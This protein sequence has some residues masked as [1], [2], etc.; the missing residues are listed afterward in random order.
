M[1]PSETDT[2]CQA[3]ST[4]LRLA[5]LAIL[6]PL[7]SFP[8]FSA[9]E[10][11]APTVVQGAQ[12][13]LYDV[14]SIR[15]FP[16]CL[17]Y[18]NSGYSLEI[19][20][21]DPVSRRILVHV[22]P[23]DLGCRAVF[24]PAAGCWPPEAAAYTRNPGAFPVL[25]DLVRRLTAGCC[26]QYQAVNQ[27]LCWISGSIEYRSGAGIPADPHD[28]LR[29]RQANCV[30]AAELAVALLREAGIPARGVRGFLAP[31]NASGMSS[32][33][34]SVEMSLGEEGLHRWI[35]IYYPGLGWVFSDPFRSVNHVSPRYLVFALESPPS[36]YGT[37]PAEGGPALAAFQRLRPEMDDSVSTFIRLL[38]RG[39]V[40]VPTDVMPSLRARE[41]MTVRRD[42]PVQFRPALV[43]W[44]TLTPGCGQPLP[45]MV[46]LS[47]AGQNNHPPVV[48]ERLAV[49]RQGLFSFTDIEAGEYRLHF[50]SDGK[51]VG[52]ER[53]VVHFPPRRNGVVPIVLGR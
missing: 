12:W 28:V 10:L 15:N 8:V 50:F 17:A 38:D 45:D 13:A 32:P 24:P 23:G 47:P 35:E 44:V 16:Y 11:A 48:A 25:A 20:G 2:Q 43:A 30:G 37:D 6:L 52:T 42:R 3:G 18:R 39:G 34:A 19:L 26:T 41:G 14:S 36:A 4:V 27:V 22:D 21:T 31:L 1:R 46:Y 5:V 49:I 7:F 29:Q 9:E 51:A 40:L 33:D 53:A